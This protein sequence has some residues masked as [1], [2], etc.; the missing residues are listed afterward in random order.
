MAIVSRKRQSTQDAGQESN[1]EIDR[2]I[3]KYEKP[4]KLK[5]R[6][7]GPIKTVAKIPKVAGK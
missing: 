7:S 5:K 6:N 3:L 1:A 2:K 4:K